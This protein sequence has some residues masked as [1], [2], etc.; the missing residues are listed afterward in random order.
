MMQ[1]AWPDIEATTISPGEQL[2][3]AKNGTP[4]GT[5]GPETGEGIDCILLA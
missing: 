5:I 3:D 4:S 1:F 2:R